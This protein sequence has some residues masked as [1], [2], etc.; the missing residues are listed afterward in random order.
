MTK[1][2]MAVLK[3]KERKVL[4]ITCKK[5]LEKAWRLVEKLNIIKNPKNM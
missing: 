2:I 5:S 3:K 1:Q 4:E